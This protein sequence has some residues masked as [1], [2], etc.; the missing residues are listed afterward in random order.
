MTC[1]ICHWYSG[2][3]LR[4][5]RRCLRYPTWSQRPSSCTL[6]LSFVCHRWVP[7]ALWSWFHLLR[8]LARMERTS[9]SRCFCRFSCR[10]LP[11][12]SSEPVLQCRCRYPQTSILL[13]SK[14]WPCSLGIPAWHAPRTGC[15]SMDCGQRRWFHWC[16]VYSFYLRLS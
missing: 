11:C 12:W 1:Y 13:Y 9:C 4:F 16:L 5:G 10:C 8:W 2:T 14:F 6:G 7:Q 15:T 3:S